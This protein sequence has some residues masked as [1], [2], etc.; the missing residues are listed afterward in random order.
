MD[1]SAPASSASPPDCAPPHASGDSAARAN[2]IDKE[3]TDEGRIDGGH[4]DRGRMGMA[5]A[6]TDRMMDVARMD[7][8]RMTAFSTLVREGPRRTHRI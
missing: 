4:T 8:G 1:L 2:Q 5:R 6:D 7:T 3:H